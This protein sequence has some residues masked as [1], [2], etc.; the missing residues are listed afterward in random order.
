MGQN[1][2]RE[3][4]RAQEVSLEK[5]RE[6]L[7]AREQAREVKRATQKAGDMPNV[8]HPGLEGVVVG[9]VFA[10]VTAI[11]A[12]RE[13]EP[14]SEAL[15]PPSSRDYREMMRRIIDT[16]DSLS[17]SLEEFLAEEEEEEKNGA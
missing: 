8:R 14:E 4:N 7:V 15:A 5:Q 13:E 16:L 1:Q 12:P 11:P 6:Y 2:R 17:D 3:K 9:K 10:K